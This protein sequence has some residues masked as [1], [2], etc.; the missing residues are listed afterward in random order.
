MCFAN[1]PGNVTILIT[2]ILCSCL[3]KQTFVCVL[4]NESESGTTHVCFET[5]RTAYHPS[6]NSNR[7]SFIK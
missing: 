5:S 4:V 6:D 1:K 7:R 2:K 3:S